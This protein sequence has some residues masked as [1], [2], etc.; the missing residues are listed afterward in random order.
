VGREGPNSRGVQTIRYRQYKTRIRLSNRIG[1]MVGGAD[2][3]QRSDERKA[4]SRPPVGIHAQDKVDSGAIPE[5]DGDPKA[6]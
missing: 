3:L 4:N 1:G 2:R 5:G 6:R